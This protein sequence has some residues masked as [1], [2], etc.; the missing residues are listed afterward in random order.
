VPQPGPAPALGIRAAPPGGRADRAGPARLPAVLLAARRPAGRRVRPG[1]PPLPLPR[2]TLG[3]ARG[4][5]GVPGD[6]AAP[7]GGGPGAGALPAEPRPHKPAVWPVP[8]ARAGL[9]ARGRLRGDEG[10]R[11][12]R[13]PAVLRALFLGERLRPGDAGALAG[14]PVRER[15]VLGPAEL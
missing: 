11:P 13:Q 4:R 15:R 8:R 1:L 14:L 2:A 9:G 6:A 3:D 12:A 7:A 5:G 10:V